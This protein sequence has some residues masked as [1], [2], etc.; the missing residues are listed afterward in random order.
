M[1]SNRELME[2]YKTDMIRCNRCGTLKIVG[3]RLPSNTNLG[4]GCCVPMELLPQDWA[5]ITD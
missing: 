4:F 3:E 2:I 5:V 1:M